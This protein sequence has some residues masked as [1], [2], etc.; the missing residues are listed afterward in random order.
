MANKITLDYGLELTN[1]SKVGWAFSLPRN[2]TCVGATDICKRLCYGN[3]IRYQSE[4]QKSKRERNFRTAEFLLKQGGPELLSE[5]LCSI[6]DYAKPRDWLTAKITGTQPVIPWT[7]RIHDIGDFYSVDYAKAWAL[8][9][10]R[11]PEC[12]FWFYTRS[13]TDGNLFTALT[14]LASLPNCQGWLSI[15]SD[16]FDL[17]IM[18]RCK[19]QSV[20]NIALLQD[21]DLNTGVLPA[22]AAMERPANVVNFPYHRGGRHVQPVRDS[23]LT[24][25]PAVVGGLTLKASKD[26]ARPCQSCNFCLP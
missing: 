24:N 3:G 8:T 20:W 7:L 5:N 1:N 11:F 2:K 4:G 9:V 10:S 16:N 13:F 26:V 12:R 22:L 6:V 14:E 21:K 19:A 23:L 15:D 18:A 17:A 25:C